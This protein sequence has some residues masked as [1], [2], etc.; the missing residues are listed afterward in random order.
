MMRT[1]FTNPDDNEARREVNDAGA[2]SADPDVEGCFSQVYER[3]SKIG[4]GK[5]ECYP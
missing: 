2:C 1:N 3:E 5:N 4:Y